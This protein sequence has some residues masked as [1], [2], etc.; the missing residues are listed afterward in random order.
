MNGM[1]NPKSNKKTDSFI[2]QTE[3]YIEK[4]KTVNKIDEITSGLQYQATQLGPITVTEI[5]RSQLYVQI[6]TELSFTF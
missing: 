2:L 3:E 4:L 1:K 6:D 5:I